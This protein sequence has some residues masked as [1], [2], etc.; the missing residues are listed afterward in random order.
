MPQCRARPVVHMARAQRRH[1]RSAGEI[2]RSERGAGL[3]ALDR[4]IDLPARRG[5]LVDQHGFEPELGGEYGGGHPGGTRADDGQL[6]R[7]P[8]LGSIIRARIWRLI[9]MPGRTSIMQL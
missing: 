6:D 4:P 1:E 8:A 7:H 5:L 9:C 3:G 2:I